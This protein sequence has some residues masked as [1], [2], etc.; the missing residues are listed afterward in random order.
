MQQNHPM[1]TYFNELV[2]AVV[3]IVKIDS[4]RQPAKDGFPF[5]EGVA[6]CLRFF[7]ELA[8]SFGFETKNYDN[9]VGE[10]IF[11]EGED[12]A[13]LAHLDVVPVGSGWKYP[14]F[15][16][17]IN[18]DP[19]DGGVL[20]TKIWG[21]GT[22]DDKAPAMACLYVLK[23]LKDEGFI[24]KRTIKLIVGCNEESGWGCIEHYKKVAKLPEEGFT[25]DG[26]FPP[27][28]AEKGIYHFFSDFKIENAPFTSLKAGE[29]AN[30]VC[31]D[32]YAT[33][34]KEAALLLKDYKNPIANT[35]FFFN[36]ERSELH[37]KGKSAH[38]SMP[39]LGAN[40]LQ[41]MLAF[42]ASFNPSVK[43][44]YDVLFLDCG[45][46]KNL[47]DE[48]GPLTMSP[49][50]ATYE[51]GILTVLTDVRYPA[52]LPL[53][54]VE[55][56]LR[57]QNVDF[58]IDH[59]QAPIYNDPKGRLISTLT[60]VYNRATGKSESPV[61]IG[62]GTYARALKCGCAFGPT[63]VSEEALAHQP[64]EYITLDCLRL[65]SEIYYDAI[66]ELTK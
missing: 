45:G 10:V 16:G 39:Q 4:T 29:A 15:A 11:G 64:N 8:Q 33:L 52:T 56:I 36:E 7:L 48:T 60:S 65:I 63:H 44:C 2:N 32:A 66:K 26:D 43:R 51:N 42:F 47:Q 24:P 59:Y 28:Y 20:G 13:V 40:A 62:G 54:A 37:V 31:P 30:M 61:A 53:S 41:A 1:T 34:T 23:A 12:F 18:D 9:Y 14:P 38:G 35:Q 5:G 55:N 25:P 50:V 21:R 6:E 49:D 27:I 22:I 19:S 3:D 58:R 57:E 17:V 46:L